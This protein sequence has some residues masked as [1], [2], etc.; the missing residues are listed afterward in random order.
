MKNI[1]QYQ[2][3]KS[4]L[5][6]FAKEIKTKFPSDKPLC[7]QEINLFCDS[8]ERDLNRDFDKI[9]LQNV[10]CKLHPKD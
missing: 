10:A 3:A 8:L 5:T 7:R 4:L 2:V 6:D 9:R 1:T